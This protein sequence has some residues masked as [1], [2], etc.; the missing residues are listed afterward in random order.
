[1][2]RFSKCHDA[3]V[4]EI[5]NFDEPADCFFFFLIK[6]NRVSCKYYCSCKFA[7]KKKQINKQIKFTCR[8]NDLS[9]GRRQSRSGSG[10]SGRRGRRR[11]SRRNRR[12][13]N[14]F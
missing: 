1:M 12:R 10:G 7:K 2:I 3:R 6:Y 13:H 8:R 9:S 4:I 11:R 5:S 14:Y